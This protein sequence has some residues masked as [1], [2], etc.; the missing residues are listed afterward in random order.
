MA[1]ASAYVSIYNFKIVTCLRHSAQCS[2][3]GKQGVPGTNFSTPSHAWII[4]D[5]LVQLSAECKLLL[6]WFRLEF[7]IMWY[8]NKIMCTP[9]WVVCHCLQRLKAELLN[10]SPKS[11]IIIL[12]PPPPQKCRCARPTECDNPSDVYS[13]VMPDEQTGGDH[14]WKYSLSLSPSLSLSLSLSQHNYVYLIY[15][16]PHPILYNLLIN[17]LFIIQIGWRHSREML[18]L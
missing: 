6:E 5:N 7:K 18:P 16:C 14:R 3:S 2:L 10:C 12:I 4:C 11:V 13:N 8:F 1:T 15:P 9:H 17:F